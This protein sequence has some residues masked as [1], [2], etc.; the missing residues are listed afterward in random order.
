MS[1]PKGASVID[2]IDPELSL[3][4]YTSFDAAVAWVKCFGKGRY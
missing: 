2:G 1:F 3:V 4:V